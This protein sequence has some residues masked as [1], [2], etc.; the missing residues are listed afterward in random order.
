MQRFL[1]EVQVNCTPQAYLYQIDVGR[2][3]V[4]PNKVFR[5][6]VSDIKL[7]EGYDS[8]LLTFEMNEGHRNDPQSENNML[9]ANQA[10]SSVYSQ[11]YMI[12]DESRIA[13]A[14]RISFTHNPIITDEKLTARV[15]CSMCGSRTVT[16]FCQT[17]KEFF[18]Q[19]H[20]YER[21]KD[22]IRVVQ[23]AV[24]GDLADGG[25][26]ALVHQ[27]VTVD[28]EIIAAA[29]KRS[30]Q[31]IVYKDNCIIDGHGRKSLEFFCLDCN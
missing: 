19:K 6:E 22:Q 1:E 4:Y 3:Y 13:P 15:V 31:P 21:H 10:A 20:D 9:P 28:P 27:R 29:R 24:K 16:A 7:P 12:F 17:E 2:V 25:F 5:D 30:S 18:C 26:N 23:E 8:I 14:Y 11:Y